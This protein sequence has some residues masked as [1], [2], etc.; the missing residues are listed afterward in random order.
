VVI[1][2][3]NDP[4]FFVVLGPDY[5]GK[6]SALTELRAGSAP[7]RIISTD[8]DLLDARHAVVADLR[9]AVGEL[10]PSLGT[11]YSAEFL[12]A[13]LQTAVVHVRDELFRGDGSIPTLVDSYYYKILA[14]CRL[15]GVAD[16][17]MFAWWRSFPQ[18]RRVIYLDVPTESAWRRSGRGAS[19]NPLEYYGQR[20]ERDGF[21]RYQRDLAK[22]MSDEI[23]GLPVTVVE[24]R[25]SPAGTADAIREVLDREFR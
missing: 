5:A 10:L 12:A 14:K 4:E 17:P 24:E 20:P 7:F 13:L 1:M 11:P 22:L 3:A 6:S 16:N 25:E 2:R 21:Q 9:R 15:A 19:L 8:G 18:P 23:H